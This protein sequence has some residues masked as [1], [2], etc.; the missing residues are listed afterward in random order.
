MRKPILASV[1]CIALV[2]HVAYTFSDK[3]MADPPTPSR[4]QPVPTLLPGPAASVPYDPTIH[5]SPAPQYANQVLNT[6]RAPGVDP[7]ASTTQPLRAPIVAAASQ[8]PAGTFAVVSDGKRSILLNTSTG[9]S[10]LMVIDNPGTHWEPI[11]LGVSKG[12]KTEISWSAAPAGAVDVQPATQLSVDAEPGRLER[13]TNHAIKLQEALDSETEKKQQLQNTLASVREKNSA[14]KKTIAD[15]SEERAE[16]KQQL[17]EAK[18]TLNARPQ[19]APP[20]P[21]SNSNEDNP[22]GGF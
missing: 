15:Y 12:G 5:H 3:L 7:T 18:K 13:A 6:G 14:L 8:G 10:W 20:Q 11:A 2:L 1:A 4:N 21:T 9:D 19:P 22:F 17:E 16:L